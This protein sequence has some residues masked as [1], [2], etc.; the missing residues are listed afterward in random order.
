M[1]GP[2]LTLNISELSFDILLLLLGDKSFREEERMVGVDRLR[3]GKA[4]PR[5]IPNFEPVIHLL[6]L[7]VTEITGCGIT[8]LTHKTNRQV[9]LV[10]VGLR[11]SQW[12][13]LS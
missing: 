7:H 1:V 5:G 4:I 9:P 8:F 10:T 13:G 12:L 6:L 3:R 11:H 2:A